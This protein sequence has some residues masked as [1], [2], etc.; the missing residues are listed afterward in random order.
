M[1]GKRFVHGALPRGFSTSP[2][3]PAALRALPCG[4]VV[5]LCGDT[6]RAVASA[7]SPVFGGVPASDD[8]ICGRRSPANRGGRGRRFAGN[9]GVRAS[10][11]LPDGGG[12][13]ATATLLPAPQARALVARNPGSG[14]AARFALRPFTYA[15][16]V[17]FGDHD[18][19]RAVNACLADAL[20][21][22]RLAALFRRETGLVLPPLAP[23]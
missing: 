22:G 16:A 20:H 21:D 23:L 11:T 6:I 13:E 10:P 9:N 12:V 2:A 19:L 15:A 14:L 8:V 4:V 3:F 5:A 17:R 18:L 1:K 7:A